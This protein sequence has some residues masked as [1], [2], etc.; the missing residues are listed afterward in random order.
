M[1]KWLTWEL[2]SH[3]EG[4]ARRLSLALDYLVFWSM[5]KGLAQLS[6]RALASIFFHPASA[7][8]WEVINTMQMPKAIKFGAQLTIPTFD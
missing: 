6:N 5:H 3:V 1:A 4:V 2:R 7:V 8:L